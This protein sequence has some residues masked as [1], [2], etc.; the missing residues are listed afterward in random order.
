[1]INITINKTF[2]ICNT[3]FLPAFNSETEST[4]GFLY[5]YL[6]KFSHLSFAFST[7]P[8][9]VTFPSNVS[10]LME[11]PLTCSLNLTFLP[12]PR[13]IVHRFNSTLD[14]IDLPMNRLNDTFDLP[15]DSGDVATDR[16]NLEAYGIDQFL[17]FLC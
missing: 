11:A 3:S 7:A 2:F 9:R 10:T 8:I 12:P 13:H 1:M 16:S 6:I 5:T 4:S 14:A 17:C 15:R